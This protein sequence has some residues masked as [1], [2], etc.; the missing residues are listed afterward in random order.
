MKAVQIVKPGDLRI[1]DMEKPVL[2]GEV[3]VLVRMTAAGNLRQRHGIYPRHERRGHLSARH[4]PRDRRRGG[5]GAGQRRKSE[6]GRSRDHRPGHRLR[7][8]LRLPHKGRPNVCGNLRV[9]GVHIDGGYREY[10]AVNDS[11]CYLLPDNVSDVDA[12]LI[13][14]TTI[15]VQCCS[16]AQL[17][18]EDTVLIIG[19]GA[20][21]TRILSIVK[22]YNPR[23]ILVADI[24]DAKLAEAKASGATHTINSRSEDVAARAHELTDGYG[25]TVVIDAACV[26]GSLLMRAERRGQR[27]PRDH[28]G[29]F[30]RAGRGEPVR[31]H[32]ERAGR[33]R[34]P[35]AEPQVP[36][37]D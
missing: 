22:L 4:R 31:H 9:R 3:N 18:S 24:D 8:L 21:G 34:Q 13:E 17:E 10:I 2:S 30:R 1:I 25:P 33:A 12:V 28:D 35:P 16:R 7:P 37:R 11:D 20:L 19:C 6:S 26:K 27:R 15:A 5:A 23:A 36:G 32:L 29:L 14:P